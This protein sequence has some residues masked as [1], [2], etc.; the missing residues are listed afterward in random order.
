MAPGFIR[1]GRDGGGEGEAGPLTGT[2]CLMA[3]EEL[4]E[5]FCHF[6]AGAR[7]EGL[8]YIQDLSCVSG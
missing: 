6:T 4:L 8:S 7:G 5:R 1:Q 3:A 2:W